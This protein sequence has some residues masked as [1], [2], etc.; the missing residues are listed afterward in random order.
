MSREPENAP[1]WTKRPW[2]VM[3]YVDQSDVVGGDKIFVT[4][5]ANVVGMDGYRSVEEIRANARLIS[6]APDLYIACHQAL[7]SYRLLMANLL[8]HSVAKGVI[9]G[10][11]LGVEDDLQDAINKADGVTRHAKTNET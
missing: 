2:S 7:E 4:R 5:S 8:D 3:D 9:Q 1:K 6:A 11:F 10:F